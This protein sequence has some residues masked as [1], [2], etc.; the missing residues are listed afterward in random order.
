VK[1]TGSCPDVG[2]GQL[3]PHKELNQGFILMHVAGHVSFATHLLTI[4]VPPSFNAKT[5]CLQLLSAGSRTFPLSSWWI[6][7]LRPDRVEIKLENPP[8]VS[9]PGRASK[10]VAMKIFNGDD[11]I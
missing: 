8:A 2:S 5:R 7:K 1:S 9:A 10:A 6:V 11:W 4:R 3:Q